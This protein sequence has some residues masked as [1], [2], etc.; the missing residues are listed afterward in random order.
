MQN[1]SNENIDGPNETHMTEGYVYCFSNPSMPGILK[2]GMTERTPDARL[3]E[4]NASDTWRPPTPY[5]I[6][7][8]KKVSNP[9]QKEQTLHNLLTQY[10]DRLHHRK[11][12][13][14]VSLEE[15]GAFFALMDGDVWTDVRSAGDEVVEDDESSGAAR[16]RGCRDMAKC[17]TNGQR[18][19]HTIGINKTWIGMYDSATNR[20]VHDAQPLSLNQFAQSHYQSERPD[21]SS[22]VNAWK[23]CEC[24]IDGVWVSTYNLPG[25]V[26]SPD[27]R[28]EGRD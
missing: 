1:D 2:I 17:F 5:A 7:F 23:E 27:M 21:R 4:A 12:F 25:D 16:V 10:T 9:A 28:R 15:V 26:G 3:R 24:E 8:S 14:R 6:A 11:E 22:S 19:R 13:F 18:I 20:V